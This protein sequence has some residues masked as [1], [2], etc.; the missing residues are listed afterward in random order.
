MVKHQTYWVLGRFTIDGSPGAIYCR[1]LI[2]VYY[3]M[4]WDNVAGGVSALAFWS[5]YPFYGSFTSCLT[6]L[7]TSSNPM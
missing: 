1:P 4:H 7:F 3:S 5:D 6:R 2:T